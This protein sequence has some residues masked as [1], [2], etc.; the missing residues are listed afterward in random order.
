MKLQDVACRYYCRKL[1]EMLYPSPSI[2]QDVIYSEC[3]RA[4]IGGR[5]VSV[6]GVIEAL[7]GGGESGG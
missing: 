6:V 4:C 5:E 2:S 7:S 1:A 3:Y